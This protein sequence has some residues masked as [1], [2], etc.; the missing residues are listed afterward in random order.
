MAYTIN[1][2]DGT[3]V[4]TI[5]DGT[6]DNTTS[7]TLFGKSFSGFGELLN[8]NL[9]KL[10]ENTASTTA[11]SAPLKGQLWMDTNTNQI[12]VY[13]GSSFK[14]TGGAKAQ[15]TEPTSASAGDLW[16]DT[17]DDQLYVYT[18]SAWHLI[19][20]VYTKGQTLSGWKIETLASAGGD[21]VVSSMYVGNTRVAILSKETFTPSASQ[22]GF[23]EIKAGFTLNSTLSAVF[24][25]T[26][27]QAANIDVS[28]TTNGSA[29]IIAGG[30][31]LRADANDTTTGSLTID[32]DTGIIIGDSQELTVSVASNN[33][34]VAQ[35]SQDKDLSFTINDGGATKTPLKFTGATGA[36]SL[37]GDV[38]VT[39]NLTI[40]GEFENSSSEINIVNDAFIK[41]NTGNS[42]ADSGVIVETS[43]TNDARLFYDVSENRWTAGENNSYSHLIRDTD[44]VADGNANKNSG[45]LRTTAA[46]LLTVT[47]LNLAAV[48]SDIT[49]STSESSVAVPTTGQITKSLKLWGGKFISDDGSNS[50]AGNRYVE[51]SAPTSGQGV[52]GDLWFVREA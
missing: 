1:K 22:T 52:D 51:T 44:A 19:G 47:N 9:V 50:I 14:P 27:T 3:V 13:D 7:L 39:G 43:D 20:P 46:G 15:A 16:T 30:N 40:S 25:G 35:T 17:D 36:I 4:A 42:E 45:F 18:G 6:I 2:T 8:E 12:K 10:L 49:S 38:T 41:L 26:N 23:A 33:V 24:E 11:P 29:T 32:N 5:T 34:T 31:L 28:G 21:K 37:T 48:G